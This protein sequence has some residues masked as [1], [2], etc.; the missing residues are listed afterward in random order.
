MPQ[1]PK[2]LKKEIHKRKFEKRKES[3]TALTKK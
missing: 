2:M 3:Q 1:I